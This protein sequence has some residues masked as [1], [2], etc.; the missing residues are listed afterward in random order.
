[1]VKRVFIVH[2]WFGNPNSDWY[3]WAKLKLEQLGYQVHVP[4]MPDTDHPKID[5]WI[6]K[7]SEEVSKLEHTD[8]SPEAT[9]SDKERPILLE[10]LKP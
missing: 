9:P 2:Q 6:S 8:I 1:M 10:L 5:A 3:P 7:L 4:E